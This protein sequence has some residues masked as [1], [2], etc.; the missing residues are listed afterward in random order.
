MHRLS[1]LRPRS[2][3]AEIVL[4]SA[5]AFLERHFA[6]SAVMSALC[7]VPTAYVERLQALDR[8]T[9]FASLHKRAVRIMMFRATLR[10]HSTSIS[11]SRIFPSPCSSLSLS[12]SAGVLASATPWAD[13]Q[14]GPPS[15]QQSSPWTNPAKA[16]GALVFAGVPIR[17]EPA[18]EHEPPAAHTARHAVRVY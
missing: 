12:G 5:A 18:L 16:L 11:N 8:M 14:D 10:H 4:T 9:R 1:I 17:L 7:G 15:G 6:E 13:L 2:V 3:Q